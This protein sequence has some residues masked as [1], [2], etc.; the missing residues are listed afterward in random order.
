M[1][2]QAR[3]RMRRKDGLASVLLMAT[4]IAAG[5]ARP[6]NAGPPDAGVHLTIMETRTAEVAFGGRHSS[7]RL[8]FE[9]ADA[10]DARHRPSKPL[11]VERSGGGPVGS[12]LGLIASSADGCGCEGPGAWLSLS[13]GPEAPHRDL[14]ASSGEPGMRSAAGLAAHRPRSDSGRREDPDGFTIEAGYSMPAFSGHFSSMPYAGLSASG[15]ATL[16][17]RFSAR[18]HDLDFALVA[19]RRESGG[20]GHRLGF[21]VNMSW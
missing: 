6:A 9:A 10:R 3:T 8:Q 4:V 14:D 11:A 15:E 20:T 18:R 21:E 17:W 19:A 7:V 2:T 16:G 1:K 12:V 5:S 13:F